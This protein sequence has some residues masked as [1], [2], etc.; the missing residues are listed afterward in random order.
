MTPLREDLRQLRK[1]KRSKICTAPRQQ[2]RAR[3][4]LENAMADAN[5]IHQNTDTTERACKRRARHAELFAIEIQSYDVLTLA[6]AHARR[7]FL[8]LTE[9][10]QW[11]LSVRAERACYLG[12]V[13]GEGNIPGNEWHHRGSRILIF[14]TCS[15]VKPRSSTNSPSVKDAKSSP[16]IPLMRKISWVC[17]RPHASKNS[18]T[19]PTLQV[20][21][22]LVPRLELARPPGD[23][24]NAVRVDESLLASVCNKK[25]E[26]NNESKREYF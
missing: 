12:R 3:L 20:L 17:P 5:D 1:A 16:S 11:L 2:S 8:D 7:V 25:L 19:S 22:R 9:Q 26:K 13:E 23:K 21:G 18:M 14:L 4:E 6:C 24:N 15:F 10:A